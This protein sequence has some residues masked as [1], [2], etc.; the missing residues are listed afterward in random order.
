MFGNLRACGRGD[1]GRGRR[2]IKKIRTVATGANEI[3][4]VVTSKGNRRH[5]VAHDLGCTRDLID[6]LALH[7]QGNQQGANLCR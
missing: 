7:P 4:G 5:Q 3:D 2:D 6:R 1:K